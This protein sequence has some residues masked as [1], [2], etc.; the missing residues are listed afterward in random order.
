MPPPPVGGGCWARIYKEENFK[1]ESLTLLGPADVDNVFTDWGFD[2]DPQFKSLIVGP[3][4]TFTVY[5]NRSFR[6]RTATF[7][8]GRYF[9]DLDEQMGVFR[10]IR[11]MRLQCAQ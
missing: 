4:G 8:P 11:S 10:S 5:D 9:R 2:W 6:D 3:K 7:A 1:G